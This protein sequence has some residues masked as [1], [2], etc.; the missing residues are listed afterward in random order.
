MKKNKKIGITLIIISFIILLVVIVSYILNINESKKEME[1]NKQL[2][3][4]N[5]QE[6]SDEIKNYNQIRSEYINLSKE[7]YYETYEEKQPS[8]TNLFTKYNQTIENIDKYI[9]NIEG[10]CNV[11]YDQ[12]EVNNICSNYKKTYE[13]IINIYIN[14]ITDYN[15][16]IDGYNTYKETNISKFNMIHSEYIDYNKDNLYEGKEEDK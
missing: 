3:K 1:E 6:L 15:N 14:D 10:K 16:K 12:L 11:I 7:F 8:Y 9:N 5:Y 13:K 2:I 4:F